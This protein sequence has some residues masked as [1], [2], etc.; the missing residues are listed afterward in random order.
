MSTLRFFTHGTLKN[1]HIELIS[2]GCIVWV[3]LN[4]TEAMTE[5]LS[6]NNVYKAEKRLIYAL[7]KPVEDVCTRT[8]SDAYDELM[9]KCMI[10]CRKAKIKVL[11]Q[12]IINL[13]K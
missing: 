9:K 10:N 7:K 1:C 12:E 2:T 6:P 11:N 5:H 4:V 8:I 13:N 3:S